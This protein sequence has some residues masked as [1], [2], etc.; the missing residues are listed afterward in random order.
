MNLLN[1]LL[2][3]FIC[4]EGPIGGKLKEQDICIHIADTCCH[5]AEANMTL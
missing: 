4:T 3:N 5:I 1:K 2:N